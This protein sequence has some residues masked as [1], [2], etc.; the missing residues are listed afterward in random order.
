MISVN[1]VEV[2]HVTKQSTNIYVYFSFLQHSVHTQP[3]INIL[4]DSA[5]FRLV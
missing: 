4:L 2:S 1:P 3:S 5:V